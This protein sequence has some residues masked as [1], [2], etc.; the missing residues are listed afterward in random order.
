MI[1]SLNSL[2]ILGTQY[3]RNKILKVA[4]KYKKTYHFAISDEE[5][6]KKEIEDVGLGDS[7]AEIN[8][9]TFGAD[10]KRYLFV[11]LIYIC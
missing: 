9:I 8:A 10:G 5:E 7:G 11:F 1:Y 6:F 3:W 4:N 2:C